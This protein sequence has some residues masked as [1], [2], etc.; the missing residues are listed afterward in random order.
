MV[1]DIVF[2]LKRKQ[3]IES[4]MAQTKL[5]KPQDCILDIL[6]GSLALNWT[7]SKEW[8]AFSINEGGSGCVK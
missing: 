8:W 1:L 2:S 7:R 6:S 5:S 4:I 3:S